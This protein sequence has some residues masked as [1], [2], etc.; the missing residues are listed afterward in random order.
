MHETNNIHLQRVVSPN[1]SQR[2]ISQ[3]DTDSCTQSGEMSE[4]ET[5]RSAAINEASS[6]TLSLSS[7]LRCIIS[8]A[9][10]TTMT[11]E[12]IAVLWCSARVSEANTAH[13]LCASLEC[14][15]TKS[16]NAPAHIVDIFESAVHRRTD[17]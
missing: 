5:N 10:L 7:A 2:G 3:R 16:A 17:Q 15:H 13:A 4:K 14:S 9:L 1:P 6:A 12:R 11:A 8:H